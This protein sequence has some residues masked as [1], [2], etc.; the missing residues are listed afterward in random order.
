MRRFNL[1]TAALARDEDD[2]PG[3]DAASARLGPA[4]GAATM[5]GTLYE[6]PPG[7]ANCPYH[8]E[9]DEE[10]LI[11]LAGRLTVRHPEGEEELAEGDVVCFPLGPAG[12]HKLTNRGEET[13]RMLLV[14]TKT[15]PGIAVYPDSDKIGVFTEDRSDNIIVRREAGVDYWDRET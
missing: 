7:Q 4:I 2:P 9:Y 6:L 11:V 12:A 8:Y 5:A 10:W 1:H 14:S 3:Y 13:V 15:M